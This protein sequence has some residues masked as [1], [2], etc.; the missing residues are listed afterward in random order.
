[1]PVRTSVGETA[2]R[3]EYCMDSFGDGPSVAA[4]D[5][6][7]GF[8]TRGQDLGASTLAFDS[9]TDILAVRDCVLSPR[10]FPREC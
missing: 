7:F 3:E 4:G 10:G 9:H 8:I 5:R 6:R 2:R 1:M